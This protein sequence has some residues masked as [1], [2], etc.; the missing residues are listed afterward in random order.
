MT[1]K[2]RQNINKRNNFLNKYFN[3]I[4]SAL[5][6]IILIFSYFYLLG[7][8]LKASQSLI[9]DNISNQKL[10]LEQQKRKLATLESVISIYSQIPANDL[11]RFNSVLPYKYKKEQLYGELEEIV[12]KNGWLLQGMTIVNPQEE[13]EGVSQRELKGINIYGTVNPLVE[14]LEV[15]I[16]V[17]GIDYL[18]VKKL[19]AILEKNIR[20]F[21]VSEI[22]FS[23]DS[24]A[25]I[26]LITYYYQDAD[27]LMVA[28][29]DEEAST[30]QGVD[31]NTYEE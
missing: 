25:E 18:G 12:T 28:S 22:S 19:L 26:K 7:P 20:L 9:I 2:E 24:Q 31:I 4:L 29:K 3:L 5:F 11:N 10:L 30:N 23:G 27:S 15:D 1:D 17:E 16:V 21:D 14:V 8:K 6:L 13:K